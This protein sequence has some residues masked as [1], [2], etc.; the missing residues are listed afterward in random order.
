[1]M[2]RN[3]QAGKAKLGEHR[4]GAVYSIKLYTCTVHILTTRYK[5]THLLCILAQI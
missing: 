2:T 5:Y 3:K 1:M 4:G